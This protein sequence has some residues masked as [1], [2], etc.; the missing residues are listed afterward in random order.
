MALSNTAVMEHFPVKNI[1]KQ[2][3]MPTWDSIWAIHFNVNANEASVPSDLG[4]GAH[5]HLRLTIRGAEYQTLTRH[6]FVRPTN[7]GVTPPPGNPHELPA[8]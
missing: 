4:G 7:P 2:A 5:G 6:V 3:G 8:Q 1:L